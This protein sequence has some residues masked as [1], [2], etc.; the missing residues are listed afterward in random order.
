[1][2]Q[3]SRAIGIREPLVEQILRGQKEYEYRSSGERASELTGM[4]IQRRLTIPAF[5]SEPGRPMRSFQP[6]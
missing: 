2:P 1:M 3:I 5:D 4:P 6:A